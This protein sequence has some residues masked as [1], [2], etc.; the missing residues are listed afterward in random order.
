MN[1][2]RPYKI[3]IS[4]AEEDRVIA[5]GIATALDLYDVDYYYY[6]EQQS[7]MNGRELDKILSN[8]YENEADFALAIVSEHYLKKKFTT[9]E[10]EAISKRRTLDE[11]YMMLVKVG[12]ADMTKLPDVTEH[13]VYF[14]WQNEFKPLVEGI[15][16]KKLNIRPKTKK[17]SKLQPITAKNVVQIRE[18]KGGTF[19]FS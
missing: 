3:A 19:N 2:N 7:V 14:P 16:M 11:G 13:T 6:P 5:S 17:K 4:F 18:N 10:F 12:E 9:M 15:L 8:I 1:Q